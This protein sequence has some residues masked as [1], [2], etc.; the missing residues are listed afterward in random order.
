MA[1]ELGHENVGSACEGSDTCPMSVWIYGSAKGV[2]GLKVLGSVPK[3]G[4]PWNLAVNSSNIAV[5]LE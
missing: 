3:L 5:L 4:T 2:L 1:S